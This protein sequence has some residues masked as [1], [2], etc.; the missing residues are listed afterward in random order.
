MSDDK[1]EQN[2]A[3]SGEQAEQQFALQKIYLKDTSFETPNSPEIFTEEW[4]PDVNVELQ[5]AGKPL[6]DEVMEVVLT[7][8]VT[9]KLGDNTAY[10]AEVHQAGVFTMSG[11]GDDE[12]V[13]MQG[14]Y[15]PNIL[16]PYARE[17]VSDLVSKGGFP[18][19]LLAPVNFD[20]LL[21]QHKQQGEA[22]AKEK[23]VVH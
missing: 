5:T 2:A 16:F 19:L 14:S 4:K 9:A 6:T 1:E 3:A 21:A 22:S 15:C 7:V 11:F 20:A 13:H 12:R 8:T 17:A 23:E 10:L 18:Q